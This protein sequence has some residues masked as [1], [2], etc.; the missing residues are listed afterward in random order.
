MSAAHLFV[1]EDG[2]LCAIWRCA[3][4]AA[5]YEFARWAAVL[6]AYFVPAGHE[7]LFQGL[8]VTTLAIL[9]LVSFL[10]LLRVLDRVR[11]SPAVALGLG[12]GKPW[13]RD[14]ALGVLFGG[15]MVGTGAALI[16]VL[17]DLRFHV[18]I[19]A[20]VWKPLVVVVWTLLASSL[21]EELTFR[22]YP[23]Q[24][25]VESVGAPGAVVLASALFGL[26]HGWN[27]HVGPFAVANT[28][29]VGVLLSLAYLR[30][31]GL[32]LPW[33]IHFGWN[34]TLGVALG[35]PVSGLTDF[36]VLGRS[37]LIGPLWLTGGAYGLEGSATATVVIV[38]GIIVLLLV[39]A[40]PAPTV[41]IAPPMKPLSIAAA[42]DH[43][44]PPQRIQ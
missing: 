21:A 3:A 33:G 31:R 29:A 25:L 34:F 30:T 12:S 42:P 20:P 39:P 36:A 5:V 26:A 8:Y 17:C 35:L 24:R 41:E 14:G 40:R 2:R 10:F 19:S 16:A 28:A 18:S 4:G 32:W 23:F 37:Q 38:V 9:L 44:A 13:L 6:I 1:A 27:P 43:E 7:W 22:G 11:S 15:A